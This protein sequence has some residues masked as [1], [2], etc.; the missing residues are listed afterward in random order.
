VY[1][2]QV[3][4]RV[5]SQLAFAYENQQITDGCSLHL[6]VDSDNTEQEQTKSEHSRSPDSR[7]PPAITLKKIITREE[8]TDL[9]LEDIAANPF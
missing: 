5:V 6:T 8:T 7:K 9:K 2:L 4:R 1:N 3:E